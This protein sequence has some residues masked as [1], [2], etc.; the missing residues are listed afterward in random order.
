VSAYDQLHAFGIDV[1]PYTRLYQTFAA[2]VAGD[3]VPDDPRPATFA[4]GVADMEVLDA[5]RRSHAER[6]WVPVP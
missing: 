5:I 2:L 3:T 1:P 4:D 6:A